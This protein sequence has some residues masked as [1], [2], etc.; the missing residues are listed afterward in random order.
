MWYSSSSGSAA[1]TSNR[2]LRISASNNYDTNFQIVQ[3]NSE[4]APLVIESDI[5]EI[6][7]FIRI[8]DFKG[9][10][11][12]KSNAPNCS[13]FDNNVDSNISIQ[14]NLIPKIDNLKG[15]ELIFGNDFS[16]PIKDYLPYGTSA[17]LKIFQKYVDQSV[18]ADLYAEKPYLYGKAL[19]SFNLINDDEAVYT[20]NNLIVEDSFNGLGLTSTERQKYYQAPENLKQFTFKQNALYKFD[21]FSG[22]LSLKNSNFNISL[23]GGFEINLSNYLNENFNSVRYV[24]KRK[25]S[26]SLS[27]EEGEPILV[28]NFEIVEGSEGDD[29]EGG[30]QDETNTSEEE[31]E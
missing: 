24:L 5:A 8:K 18:E 23:P 12:H 26:D 29:T 10:V 27:V 25:V 20:P 9:S 30:A 1:R 7:L 28:I 16:Y 21:F 3:V 19:S 4:S 31:V 14:V 13:Y 11:E 17:A 22:L 6:E 15:D 2:S